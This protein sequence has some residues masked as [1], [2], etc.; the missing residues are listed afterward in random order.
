MKKYVIACFHLRSGETPL[1]IVVFTKFLWSCWL[2]IF[3]TQIFVNSWSYEIFGASK[4]TRLYSTN[5]FQN[6]VFHRMLPIKRGSRGG[7]LVAAAPRGMG[8]KKKKK[9]EKRKKERKKET[10]KQTKKKQR[11]NLETKKEREWFIVSSKMPSIGEEKNNCF[12]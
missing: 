4:H 10:K 5:L 6:I 1:N 9:K 2:D 7:A 3:L 11:K 12:A 8:R